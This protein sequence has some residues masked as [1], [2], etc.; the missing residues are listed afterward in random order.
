MR[1]HGS[2]Q[3]LEAVRLKAIEL[4]QK[5]MQADEIA[6]AL[7]RSRRWLQLTLQQ[8]RKH[9]NAGIRLKP[10]PGAK[11]KLSA[12]QRRSL[13]KRLLQ[14][15]RANGFETDLWT[16]PRVREL[17]LRKYGVAY[18]VEY[19]PRLLSQL[20]LSCQKPTRRAKQ[21]DEAGIASWV[22][23]DWERIKKEPVA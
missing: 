17:I 3:D 14:G 15:A 19:V 10:C 6:L 11:P 8:F 4:H 21:R 9:G 20:G 5:G 13:L 22:H 16:G 23:R 12:K 7:D 18:H 2:P 1:R